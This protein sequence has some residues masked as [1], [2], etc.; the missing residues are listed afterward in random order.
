MHPGR[1][2]PLMVAIAAAEET[3]DTRGFAVVAAPE[4]DKLEFLSDRFG[5]TEGG[6]DR[7]CAAREQLDVGDAFGQ[8]PAD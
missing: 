7:L 5:E 3:D 2:G 8:Q 1:E 4:P 6:L